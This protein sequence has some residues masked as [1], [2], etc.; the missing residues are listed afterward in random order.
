MIILVT[1]IGDG[2]KIERLNGILKAFQAAQIERIGDVVP[3]GGRQTTRFGQYCL[4][5]DIVYFATVVIER[6][7]R[8]L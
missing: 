7:V 2:Y 1:K 6:G 5:T 8:L 4:S 3:L